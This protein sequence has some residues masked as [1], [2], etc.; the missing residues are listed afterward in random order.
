MKCGVREEGSNGSES[1]CYAISREV[2]NITL[3]AQYKLKLVPDF[4]RCQIY[5]KLAIGFKIK[6]SD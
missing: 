4:I 6:I 1:H 2:L 5:K 3:V